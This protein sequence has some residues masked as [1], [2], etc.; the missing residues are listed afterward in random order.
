MFLATTSNRD[1][2]RVAVYEPTMLRARGNLDERQNRS[3]PRLIGTHIIVAEEELAMRA[4]T[5]GY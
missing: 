5:S 1:A 2:A 4:L 3:N